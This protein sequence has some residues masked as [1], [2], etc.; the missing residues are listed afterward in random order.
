MRCNKERTK[1]KDQIKLRTKR[2]S[3]SMYEKGA[4]VEKTKRQYILDWMSFVQ[5][6]S[7][8]SSEFLQKTSEA[9]HRVDMER[10]KTSLPPWKLALIFTSSNPAKCSCW[11]KLSVT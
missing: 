6:E 2:K 10:Q 9:L 11:N 4:R 7:A 1:V 5:F 8:L 3:K